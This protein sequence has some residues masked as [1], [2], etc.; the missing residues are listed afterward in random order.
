MKGILDEKFCRT[1]TNRITNGVGEGEGFFLF[2]CTLLFGDAHASCSWER[3]GATARRPKVTLIHAKQ[4]ASKVEVRQQRRSK[5][6]GGKKQA[7]NELNASKKQ[8]RKK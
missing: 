7:T 4:E 2:F 6:E 5:Q 3:N 1:I 8:A